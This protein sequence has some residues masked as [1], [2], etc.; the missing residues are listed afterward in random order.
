MQATVARASVEAKNETEGPVAKEI[1]AKVVFCWRITGSEQT[2]GSQELQRRLP[3]CLPGH[4]QRTIELGRVRPMN[5]ID[6]VDG[7]KGYG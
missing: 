6:A 2:K 5:R 3:E 7:P 4:G 1:S